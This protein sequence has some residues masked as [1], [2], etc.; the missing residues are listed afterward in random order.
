LGATQFNLDNVLVANIQSF[1]GC[2]ST[3]HQ[4]RCTD[5]QSLCNGAPWN[6]YVRFWVDELPNGDV[7]DI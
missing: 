2:D 6:D 7:G 5:N 3:A 4:M 1:G